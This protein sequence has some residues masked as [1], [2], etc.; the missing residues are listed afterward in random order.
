MYLSVLFAISNYVRILLIYLSS[1]TGRFARIYTANR[2]PTTMST[3]I[4]E[5]IQAFNTIIK[6]LAHIPR[7]FPLTPHDNL[8]DKG[9]QTPEVR[10]ELKLLNAFAQLMVSRYEVVAVTSNRS[11][12]LKLMASMNEE[13][14][15]ADTPDAEAE[16]GAGAEPKSKL[17]QYW[18]S[19]HKWI[20]VAT[21]NS[22]RD[23]A[24][25]CSSKLGPTTVTPEVPSDLNGRCVLSYLEALEVQW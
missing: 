23:D 13:C 15:H 9:W 16:A 14:K 1:S 2:A 7:K 12:T 22:R 19:F 24:E 25:T 10:Q 17:R 11:L 6:I 3:A 20:L 8:S 5:N 18:D 21:L 4:P